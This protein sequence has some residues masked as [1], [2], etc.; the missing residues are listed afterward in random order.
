M[1][2]P[3]KK[4]GFE[5]LALPERGAES[6]DL[7][8]DG[9]NPQPRL[10]ESDSPPHVSSSPDDSQWAMYQ[11]MSF[12][13]RINDDIEIF[14][15]EDFLVEEEEENDGSPRFEMKR[16]LQDL[17]I[18]STIDEESQEEYPSTPSAVTTEDEGT[19]APTPSLLPSGKK[20]QFQI[21][22]HVAPPLSDS[23]SKSD[24]ES[25]EEFHSDSYAEVSSNEEEAMGDIFAQEQARTRPGTPGA[26][27]K[28]RSESEARDVDNND[29]DESDEDAPR[30]KLPRLDLPYMAELKAF[31]SNYDSRAHY[32]S[33]YFQQSV[34]FDENSMVSEK[35]NSEQENAQDPSRD[36]VSP[37]SGSLELAGTRDLSTHKSSD[38]VSQKSSSSLSRTHSTTSTGSFESVRRKSSFENLN[39]SRGNGIDKD[40]PRSGNAT[41]VQATPVRRRL[42]KDQSFEDFTGG[43]NPK[44]PFPDGIDDP[45]FLNSLLPPDYDESCETPALSDISG[46][47]INYPKGS[48]S[49]EDDRQSADKTTAYDADPE[50]ESVLDSSEKP[51]RK[52]RKRTL[53]NED[54]EKIT[55]AFERMKGE[56]TDTYSDHISVSAFEEGI[57]S[58]ST[59]VKEDL[60]TMQEQPQVRSNPRTSSIDRISNRLETQVLDRQESKSMQLVTSGEGSGRRSTFEAH[61]TNSREADQSEVSIDFV[62]EGDDVFHE[63]I[64]NSAI[65]LQFDGNERDV[66]SEKSGRLK[67]IGRKSRSFLNLS[68]EKEIDLERE[69]DPEVGKL[70]RSPRLSRS[71]FDLS[72]EI[73]M[74][75]DLHSL[76]KSKRLST[77]QLD[78]RKEKQ[79][80]LDSLSRS[81]RLSLSQMEIRREKEVDLDSLGS[82]QR[83]KKLSTSQLDIHK[84]MEVDLE[85]LSVHQRKGMNNNSIIL[86]HNLRQGVSGLSN[87]LE[88]D[89]D[90][91]HPSTVAGDPCRSRESSLG[92]TVSTEYINLIHID[93]INHIDPKTG[94]PFSQEKKS[95]RG[96]GKERFAPVNFSFDLSRMLVRDHRSRTQSFE[97]TRSLSSRR[98]STTGMER[99][100]QRSRSYDVDVQRSRT[101]SAEFINKMDLGE[102]GKRKETKYD[103]VTFNFDI[104]GLLSESLRKS[105]DNLV[106]SKSRRH[107]T[108][109]IEIPNDTSHQEVSRRNLSRNTKSAEFVNSLDLGEVGTRRP[110]KFDPVAFRFDLTTYRTNNLHQADKTRSLSSRRRPASV[111]GTSF[112]S[113]SIETRSMST[114]FVNSVDLGEIGIRRLNQYDPCDLQI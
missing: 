93:N 20:P 3:P 7:R 85:K 60:T 102:M 105:A 16:Q 38:N 99:A 33:K 111:S 73:W 90:Q 84:A 76:R 80:D 107:T 113:F 17:D 28:R 35:S 8:Q 46:G 104:S 15:E 71:Q 108:S 23:G 36:A 112:R 43:S 94:I 69:L 61:M 77:S 101:V 54:R 78:V 4:S 40:S 75:L 95:S 49:S 53:N 5:D 10:G 70:K 66:L 39:N 12:T 109:M 110:S 42:M 25:F 47:S 18:Y 14:D 27:V 34:Q 65:G 97:R 55:H 100:S 89:I 63:P 50:D 68:I 45:E 72:R 74:D 83:P 96:R 52:K 62:F 87:E 56:M 9:Q 98:H 19:P 79:V 82:R 21:L 58:K 24:F 67:R 31:L 11:N 106:K 88:F 41:P 91:F 2:F 81:Q 22:K 26:A 1:N 86:N 92:R 44:N 32:T 37:D 30:Y 114:E 57:K 51:K 103:P 13:G 29:D 48:D 64:S 59:P 6:R